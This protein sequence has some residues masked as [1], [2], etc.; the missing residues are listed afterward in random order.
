MLNDFYNVLKPGCI[1]GKAF[2]QGSN[3]VSESPLDHINQLES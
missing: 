2:I 1:V 3:E